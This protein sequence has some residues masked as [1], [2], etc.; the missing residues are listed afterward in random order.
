[1]SEI[2]SDVPYDNCRQYYG[3][4]QAGNCPIKVSNV[5]L[6]KS[7]IKQL[8]QIPVCVEKFD[9]NPQKASKVMMGSKYQQAAFLLSVLWEVND[10]IKVSFMPDPPGYPGQQPQWGG[11]L[12]RPNAAESAVGVT[13]P[14]MEN[15]SQNACQTNGDCVSSMGSEY[16]CINGSCQPNLMPQWYTKSIVLSNTVETLSPAEEE[17]EQKVRTMDPKE[18]IK[19]IILT[20]LQPLISVK[21]EF[22]PEGG[23]IRINLDNRDGSWSLVGI[24]CRTAPS[25]EPT[26]S[27][28]WLD[29]GTIIHEFCHALGMI[30]E[31]QNPVGTGI[32]WNVQKVFQWASNTQGWDMYTTCSNIIK[33]YQLDSINGSEYDV[34]S[35]MLY[36]FPGEL[37]NSGVGTTRNIKLSDLDKQWL[38]KMYPPNG[39]PREITAAGAG[40]AVEDKPV[41]ESMSSSTIR[42]III[43]FVIVVIIAMAVL[44]IIFYNKRKQPSVK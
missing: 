13:Q 42:W 44:A 23:D 26:M 27:F 28:G 19:Y 4:E 9:A 18:A 40:A 14:P 16:S 20:L 8:Q 35:I 22:V 2:P 43:A 32:D 38:G 6:T 12:K 33:K 17:V 29:V 21:F 31:H 37:T 10:V 36:S 25:N 41:L 3:C 1:M 5:S 15:I 7:D 34:K 24:Q 30:H 11:G 39:G